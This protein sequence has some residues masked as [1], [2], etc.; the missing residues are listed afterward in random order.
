MPWCKEKVLKR[1]LVNRNYRGAT[2]K[3]SIEM[4][5]GFFFWMGALDKFSEYINWKPAWLKY[6]NVL[7]CWKVSLENI[8]SMQKPWTHLMLQIH[9]IHNSSMTHFHCLPFLLFSKTQ[10]CILEFCW[11]VPCKD[12]SLYHEGTLIH[13]VLSLPCYR[14]SFTERWKQGD[15]YFQMWY[16]CVILGWQPPRTRKYL[17][18]FNSILFFFF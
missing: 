15:P 2:W 10:K 14:F 4:F 8:C 6:I 13:L 16:F 1:R 5:L 12:L 3:T 9:Q 7:L 17:V 11:L 18:A